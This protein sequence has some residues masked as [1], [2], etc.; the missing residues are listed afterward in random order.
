MAD[1]PRLLA[2]AVDCENQATVF[3][4][5][6]ACKEVRASRKAASSLNEAR[7]AFRIHIYEREPDLIVI[8]DP[9]SNEN[10]GELTLSIMRALAQEA[11][12]QGLN[13]YRIP[14]ERMKASGYLHRAALRK[15]LPEAAYHLPRGR[16]FP[17]KA[18]KRQTVIEA[19][20]LVAIALDEL[21]DRDAA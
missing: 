16:K 17:G 12:D 20:A 2:V 21:N 7:S 4:I 5:D 8:E 19:L 6:G 11:A 3:V 1:K 13:L 9:E 18:P 15:R 10:K 14:R